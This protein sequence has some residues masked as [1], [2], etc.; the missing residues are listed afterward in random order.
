MTDEIRIY[1]DEGRP[2]RT[3]FSVTQG[4]VQHYDDV[5]DMMTRDAVQKFVTKHKRNPTQEAV[6]FYKKELVRL[7]IIQRDLNTAQTVEINGSTI[8]NEA[9]HL[10]SRASIHR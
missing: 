4:R 7:I 5:I 9:H 3:A 6:A 10:P 1:S 8:L 2:V